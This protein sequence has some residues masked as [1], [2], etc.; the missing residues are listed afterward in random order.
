MC[1]LFFLKKVDDE[2]L[3]LLQEI[4]PIFDFSTGNSVSNSV[5]QLSCQF[6]FKTFGGNY[7]SNSV[8]QLS[9]Q[10]DFKTFGGAILAKNCKA[11]GA[12]LKTW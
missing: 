2:Q 10:F 11:S 12:S 3:V 1:P 5:T 6:N 9:F 4:F 7:I 8:T